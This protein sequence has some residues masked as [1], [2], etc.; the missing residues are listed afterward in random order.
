MKEYFLIRKNTT[1]AAA[2]GSVAEKRIN[3]GHFTVNRLFFA[4][5]IHK[6][7]TL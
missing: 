1:N 2:D 6:P 3:D 5:S 4:I 7:T